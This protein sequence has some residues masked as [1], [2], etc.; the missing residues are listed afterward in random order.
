M[1]LLYPSKQLLPSS[2][3]TGEERRGTMDGGRSFLASGPPSSMTRV[4]RCDSILSMTHSGLAA[5]RWF[6]PLALLGVLVGFAVRLFHLGGESL[7][8]DETVS[9]LLATRSL[10]A[11]IA[12]TAG[13]IHPPAYYLLLHGWHLL[14][15]PS[16]EHGLE[17]LLAW[18]S[19]FFGMM[20][21][22][23][24]HALGR[25]LG[26][27]LV[28]LLA[29]W[30]AAL[31]P[32]QIWYSQEVRMY[33][34]GACCGLLCL[35]ALLQILAGHAKLRW[36]GLYTL[37]AAM[38]FYTLYYFLFL[39][40]T[41]NLLALYSFWRQRAR[42]WPGW[43]GAQLATLILWAPWLPIF[44]RQATD[45]PVPGWRTVWPTWLDLLGSLGEGFAA[46]W[47]GQ[48]APGE[49]EWPWALLTLLIL[50]VGIGHAWHRANQ[51]NALLI[52]LSYV[53]LPSGLIYLLSLVLTP[54]YHVRYLFTYAPPFVLIG[55]FGLAN[56]WQWRPRWAVVAMIG[57]ALGSAASLQSFWYA[58]IHRADDHRQAV[59]LLADQWRPGDLILVNAGWVYS[60]LEIYWPTELGDPLAALPPKLNAPIRLGDGSDP[61]L[62]A[63]QMIRTG[64]V[65]GP[66]TL[67]WA[68]PASDFFAISKADSIAALDHLAEQAERI[69]HYRLYDTVSDPAGVI[70]TW[71]EEKTTRR[72]DQSFAGR[73]FL[74]LELYE[75]PRRAITPLG[76][77]AVATFAE[78]LALR[79]IEL[80]TT[81]QAGERL[82]L[83]SEWQARGETPLPPLALSLRLYADAADQVLVAQADAPLLPP[84]EQW[85]R[86]Q[87]Y[88]LPLALSIPAATKPG[89]YRVA[90]VLYTQADGQALS[91]DGAAGESSFALGTVQVARSSL[92]PAVGPALARF[93]YL[94]LLAVMPS[95][96]TASSGGEFPVAWIWRARP[97]AYRDTYLARL[98]L[99]SPDEQTVQRWETVL[100]GWEYPT[101]EWPPLLPVRDQQRLL[102][103]PQMPAG[104]YQLLLQVVRQS[105]Q[106]LIPARRA[107]WQPARA[108]WVLGDVDIT[109]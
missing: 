49:V 52:S 45:P 36:Y 60:A 17:F 80:P 102:V 37:S 63:P 97:S 18:P 70:R 2:A 23:L 8:Y 58:P 61:L 7:W 3:R 96:F 76:G 35:W 99:Q 56:L 57:F 29:L 43:V 101:G 34:M 46:F 48:S 87:Q 22:V 13:D 93:D 109:P 100:G 66:A 9:A 62:A 55:A 72:F 26:S 5:N 71:L 16:L 19:L 51:R 1:V 27:P 84:T 30:I 79:Q 83:Q 88:Q 74:R 64:S 40:A 4:Q 24:L 28:G 44:W 103:D 85:Q 42:V 21:L 108:E 68:D 95:Q 92:I 47:I 107:W 41:L 12:H 98:L 14:T 33:T 39:W 20:L 94:E 65:D 31:H 106:A 32:Y 15:K 105:D 25:R 54:L 38:G 82:Y 69:W 11:I 10:P 6:R 50:L 86:G 90:L 104:R 81:V 78:A 91:I 59:A 67:G 89:T 53:L 75:I 73:D 77:E